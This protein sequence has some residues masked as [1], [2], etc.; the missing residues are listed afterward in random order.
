MHEI[1][2]KVQVHVPFSLLRE[3]LLPTVIREGIHPEISFSHNDLD[4]F[5]ESDFR[6]TADLLADAG[7]SVTFHAPFMDLRPGALDPR[8]RQTT[9]ERLRQVFVLVPW[10]RP[11]SVVCH[12]SFDEKYYVSG[13]KMWLHNSL[14]TWRRLLEYVGET[15]TVIALENV[16]ERDPHQLRLLLDSL[17]SPK[18]RFCFDTGHFN[19]FAGAPLAEWM[20]ILGGSLGEIHIHDNR[21]T[22]DEHL[23][24][25]EGTF[26]FGELLAI[27]R[28]RNLKPI[29][30]IESHTEKGLWRML[31]NI[32]CMKLLDGL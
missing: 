20:E 31:E 25:G 15:E 16:Y 7:H 22:A 1:L 30:T 17:A 13:E 10:F 32:R 9:L 23:P 8:I 12:P 19:V 5:T 29:L 28:E 18:F 26:P 3:K 4:R 27:L 24:A 2:K 11:R 21:G 14:E 6:E